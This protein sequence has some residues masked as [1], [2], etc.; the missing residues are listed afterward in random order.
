MAKPK[1]INVFALDH[2]Y[3]AMKTSNLITFPTDIVPAQDGTFGAPLEPMDRIIYADQTGKQYFIG[4]FAKQQIE[5][6]PSLLDLKEKLNEF[7]FRSKEYLA[8]MLTAIAIAH[9][10]ETEIG[11]R[12]FVTG[13]PSTHWHQYNTELSGKLE[14]KHKFTVTFGTETREMTIQIKD[15]VVIPQPYGTLSLY[16]YNNNGEMREENSFVFTDKVGIVDFGFYT[17]D[18]QL[19]NK[20]TTVN[21]GSSSFTNEFETVSQTYL[22]IQKHVQRETGKTIV[23]QTMRDKIAKGKIYYYE[24]GVQKTYDLKTIASEYFSKM[25]NLIVEKIVNKWQ[26]YD[27]EYIVLSGGG[28][29]IPEI[30]NAF[31]HVYGS[32]ILLPAQDMNI[33]PIYTNV[34]GYK[35]FGENY[36]LSV[37]ELEVSTPNE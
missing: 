4:N 34:L 6:K 24:N 20:F 33:D 5:A 21:E 1:L 26:N 7:Y 36:L 12:M 13:L 37:G 2:G 17:T 25:A 22:A 14:G 30:V 19:T 35:N 23:L 9:P 8:T 27:L 16:G 28:S 31:R 18:A 32:Q 10:D 11:I 3:G 29:A 15:A